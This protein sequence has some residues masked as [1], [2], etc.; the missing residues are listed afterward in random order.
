MDDEVLVVIGVGGMGQAIARRQGTGRKVVLAD[1]NTETLDAAADRLTVEGHRVTTHHVDVSARE[2]VVE[3]ARAASAIGRVAQVAHT[4][5]LSGAQAPAA[6][7]LEV[8][9]LGVALVLEVFGQ[10]IAPG[11][12]GIVIASMAGHF[13]APFTQE[14]E[15]SLANTPADDLLRLPFTSPDVITDPH[16]AYSIAKRANQIQVQA[17]SVTWG[18]RS[19]RINSISPGIISTPQGQQEL[20]SEVGQT[21]RAMIEASAAG[22]IGT[23]DDIA[24]AAAFLL[25]PESNFIT[26]TDVLV[27]GGV[28]AAARAG[29]VQLSSE[30]ARPRS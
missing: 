11:G 27:D 12:A 26:G 4:A 23:P 29:R 13:I 21:M 5:G 10:V 1:F 28:V 3:L 8:D 24:S 9:L 14:Q 19:A 7:I 30:P 20:A 2:S 15:T 25:G 18:R 22:R 17:A 6:A 16:T